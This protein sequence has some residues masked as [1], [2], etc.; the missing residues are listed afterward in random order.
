LESLLGGYGYC[1]RFAKYQG[2]GNDFVMI[3][4]PG[5]ELK[6]SAEAVRRVCDRRFGIGADGV[7]RVAPG[8]D[9]GELFMDYVNSDGSIGEMCGNGIRCLALFARAEG[10][11][12]ARELRVETRA[13][14]KTIEVQPED[15]VR[16]DMGAPIF[17]PRDIPVDWDGDDALRVRLTLGST[18]LEVAC[19]SMGNPHAVWFVE[20]PHEAPVTT[21]GPAIEHHSAFPRGANVEFVRVL[22]PERIRMRVWERGSGETLAC[23]TGACAAAVAT[24]LLAGGGERITVELRGGEAEVEWRGSLHE[25][26]PVF[27][28]GPAA[29]VFEGEIGADAWV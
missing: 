14:V 6:L 23:G 1:V 19:L 11:T 28:T 17:G 24:R 13:G 26:A 16:V 18:E 25:A 20:D 29:K 21:L 7:I 4:D 3:A 22:S 27:L 10:M 8:R 5:D 15:R 9:G 2:I 12:S